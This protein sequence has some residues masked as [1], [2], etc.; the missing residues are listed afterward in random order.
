LGAAYH[1]PKYTF[2]ACV[3]RKHNE[4]EPDIPYWFQYL[5]IVP[6]VDMVKEVDWWNDN[7]PITMELVEM[8]YP[9]RM[10]ERLLTTEPKTEFHPRIKKSDL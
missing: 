7:P 1:L 6:G 10:D 9:S 8:Q 3:N 4:D 5:Y 2:T